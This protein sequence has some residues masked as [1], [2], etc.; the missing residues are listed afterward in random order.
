MWML[1]SFNSSRGRQLS[2]KGVITLMVAILFEFYQLWL[3]MT[4]V[5]LLTVNV[6][7]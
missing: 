3:L 6:F 1:V 5:R 7:D 2:L 4:L